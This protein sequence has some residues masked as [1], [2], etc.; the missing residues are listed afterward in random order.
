MPFPVELALLGGGLGLLLGSLQNVLIHRLPIGES[1][2]RPRRSYCP[3]CRTPIRAIDNIP[4]LSYALLRGRCRTCGARIS[5]RY[6]LVEGGMGLWTATILAMHG[7][8][9]DAAEGIAFGFV[10]LPLAIIDARTYRLPDGLVGTGALLAL[11]IALLRWA[12]GGPT[13]AVFERFIAGG[14]GFGFL[15]LVRGIGGIAA[16]REAMGFGD[17]KFFGMIGLFLGNL[18]LVAV[19]ATIG[20]ILG[21]AVG[22]ILVLRRRE[23]NRAIPFGPFLAVAAA[24]V[25][26]F[27]DPVVDLLGRLAVR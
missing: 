26:L 18:L 23:G 24:F 27:R 15:A 12:L 19:T 22:S 1:V 5:P 16:R 20:A 21:A 14:F 3:A 2:L 13:G 7:R 17:V 25:Y 10:L 9:F 8:T 11:G 6:P 4:L